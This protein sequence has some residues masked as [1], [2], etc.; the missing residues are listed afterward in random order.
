MGAWPVVTCHTRIWLSVY[1]AKRVLP[2]EDQ[3]REM[4]DTGR[5]LDLAIIEMEARGATGAGAW[6]A[7]AADAIESCRRTHAGK[8]ERCKCNVEPMHSPPTSQPPEQI[9][10]VFE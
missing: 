8:A 1:P 2:S 6:K 10:R 9:L 5:A 7:Y 3:A 4:Q